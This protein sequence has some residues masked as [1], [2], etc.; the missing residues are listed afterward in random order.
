MHKNYYNRYLDVICFLHIPTGGETAEM[1]G[2]YQG[3]D[4]DVAGFAVGAVPHSRLLLEHQ[5]IVAGDA[6]IAL[7]SSGLQHEDFVVLEEVLLSHSLNPHRMKGI[8]GGVSLCESEV[9]KL[10]ISL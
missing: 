6:I 3:K 2:M 10:M 9:L 4:Y 5:Q 7:T 8:N 1:P